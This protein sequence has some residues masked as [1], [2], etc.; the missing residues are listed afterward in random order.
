MAAGA[1][2]VQ[3][4]FLWIS[5]VYLWISNPSCGEVRAIYQFCKERDPYMWTPKNE[6]SNIW[7]GLSTSIF[8]DWN[9]NKFSE[10]FPQG[11]RA[12][13]TGASP[14][15]RQRRAEASTGGADSLP[16][17]SIHIINTP[18]YYYD[19]YLFFNIILESIS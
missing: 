17:V 11:R 19:S 5:R 12:L 2:V 14:T 4:S 9:V 8:A 13:L 6:F 10:S 7:I 16:S 15:S 3:T 18:Y 1:I